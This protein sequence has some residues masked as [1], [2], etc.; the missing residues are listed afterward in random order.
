[1][2][3]YRIIFRRT[4]CNS[5]GDPHVD[6]FDGSMNDVYDS[7]WYTLV[8][9]TLEAQEDKNVPYFRVSQE[10]S[11]FICIQI[12]IM[13]TSCN[14][15]FMCHKFITFCIRSGQIPQPK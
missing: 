11:I 2:N 14:S 12:H 7:N 3:Q 8:E 4:M 6:T 15:K 10:K 1:M 9:P 5:W 13:L